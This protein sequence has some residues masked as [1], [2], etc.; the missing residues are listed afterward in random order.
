MR[1][2]RRAPPGSMPAAAAAAAAAASAAA[3]HTPRPGM[4]PW[5]RA[6]HSFLR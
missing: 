2:M 3:G 5:I 1:V 4:T 6:L